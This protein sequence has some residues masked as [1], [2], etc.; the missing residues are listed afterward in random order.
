MQSKRWDA[1]NYQK[2]FSFVPGY[3]AELL[4]LLQPSPGQRILDL[5]C[6][7]GTL[8]AQIHK[9]GAEVTGLDS[10]PE[11][12]ALARE[13]LPASVPLLLA[14]APHFTV[15]TPFDSV[16]SNAVFHWIVD[17]EGLAESICQALRLGGKLVCEFGGAGCCEALHSALEAQFHKRGFVYPRPFYFPTIGQHAPLLE[18]H[19][20]RVETAALFQRPT[21]LQGKDAAA[22]W[23]RMFATQ[24]LERTPP[25][26][27]EL[28]LHDAQESLRDTL[29]HNGQWYADY[30]RIRITAV[31]VSP[32][33]RREPME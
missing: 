22:D 6:G 23:M 3:G 17:Q 31:R 14:D 18:R 21:P 32:V 10:S 20:L 33:N 5:G 30:V 26:E 4:S 24:A 25:Q 15:D 13:N 27:R 16:F 12:L 19:N 11:M 9:A 2:N 7:N 28:I 8:T 1:K 29:W